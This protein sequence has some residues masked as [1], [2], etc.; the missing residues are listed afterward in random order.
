[1][2]LPFSI[3]QF[4]DIFEKYNRSVW[5]LQLVFYLMA[6]LIVWTSMVK[7]RGSDKVISS[8]LSFFWIWMGA[9]YHLVY[10][11][12]INKAALFSAPPL[13]CKASCFFIWALL[14]I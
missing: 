14:K 7:F 8:L 1:M 12:A 9:I 3:E 13:S 5:P 6:A 2:S 11:T 4:L 10:F